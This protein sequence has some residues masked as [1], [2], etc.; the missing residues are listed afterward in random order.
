MLE[1]E[2]ACEL[3]FAADDPV[4]AVGIVFLCVRIPAT[5]KGATDTACPTVEHGRTFAAQQLT[6]C[7]SDHG[8]IP[9]CLGRVPSQP[10]ALA[11]TAGK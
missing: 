8:A 3:L 1:G 10:R 4:A 5:K 9:P 7:T 11:H 6:T 2:Q